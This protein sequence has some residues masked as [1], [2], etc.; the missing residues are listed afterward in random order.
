MVKS[1]YPNATE[2]VDVT[3]LRCCLGL[4]SRSSAYISGR[5]EE[6]I[7]DIFPFPSSGMIS[8][9]L[10]NARCSWLQCA[11]VPNLTMYP[12]LPDARK[13]AL[14]QSGEALGS[15]R[16]VGKTRERSCAHPGPRQIIVETGAHECRRA[17]KSKEAS[18]VVLPVPATLE[19]AWPAPCA[20]AP[21]C[22]AGRARAR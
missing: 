4:H 7:E 18:R 2:A 11:F 14:H 13:A 1:L 19:P 9:S 8:V 21:V 10:R 5:R 20:Y 15:H 22:H 12:D 3:P 6:S 16:V 17:R